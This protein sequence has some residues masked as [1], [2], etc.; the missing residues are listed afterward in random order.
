MPIFVIFV[1]ASVVFG[2][3]AMLAPALPTYGPRI[4]LAGALTLAFI[5]AGAIFIAALFGWD[6]LVIDYMWFA[7]IVG[8][9]FTGTLSA[10]MFRA[11]AEGG[12]RVYAGWPGPRELAFLLLVGVIF[13]VPA[14]V[15][16][17]PLDTD[18][19][20]F[21]LLSLSLRDSGSLTTLAPFHPE[22][23][24]LYSPGFPAL[25][26]YL[27]G[28]LNAG[29]HTIQFGAGVVLCI[30]LVWVAYDLGNEIDPGENRRTG[31]AFGVASLLSSGLM[32]AFLDS[33]YT[34]LLGLVF[35]LA[36]LTFV[37]RYHR[38]GKRA[39]FWAAAV[40][41]AGVP[42][43]QPDMTVILIV[44][45]VPW[46]VSM[47]A[48]HPRPSIRRWLGL[49]VGIPALALIGIS[50]WVIKLLP[51][52][53]SEISSP[54]EISSSHLITATVYHLTILPFALGG[55][56]LALRRRNPFDLLMVGWL[57][58]V[59]DLSSVGVLKAIMPWMPLFKY[60]YPFSVAWHGPIIPYLYFGANA[61][62]WLTERIG[63]EP[64]ER[65]LTRISLPLMGAVGGIV[66][67]LG[68]AA[69]SLSVAS[70]NTPL[71][72][73][74]AFSSK[75]DVQ[76][77]TWL[78]ENTPRDTLIL[79]HPGPHEGDWVPVIS[80]R[81][82]VFF[83]P[84]PFFRHTETVD[85]RQKALL[86]FWENPNDPALG[87]LLRRYGVDYVIVPQIM[88]KPELLQQMFRWRPPLSEGLY[89]VPTD[90]PYLELVIDFEGAQVFRVRP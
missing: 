68:A 78:R 54:F 33:H 63:R 37:L 17:V 3:G 25:V 12:T 9:F 11:E 52:L 69:G 4:G 1:F 27:G 64:W 89:Q 2:A 29:L 66:L 21:G 16:P 35:S 53:A 13:T 65:W 84:Q 82:A 61:F 73:Y 7:A 15:F 74:G 43:A 58:L 46:L 42:L 56:A 31:I 36:F 80:A 23:E 70:K 32:T 88:V 60:D 57:L 55:I 83:R 28:R 14:L 39:D 51:L 87:E 41:L 50:P 18:A 38:E 47:W 76:A 26:A 30:L 44:G 90:A 45:Y 6:T 62:L 48:A 49:A 86:R 8:I 79:N 59:V 72:F 5:T 67:I 40:C 81:E 19:Q 34:A 10:G 85:S 71:Q 24:Y 20:G 77:M 75:A 22:I